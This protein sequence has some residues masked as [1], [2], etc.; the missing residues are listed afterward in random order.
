M[1]DWSSHLPR[2]SSQFDSLEIHVSVSLLRSSITQL[3]IDRLAQQPQLFEGILFGSMIAGHSPSQTL[4]IGNF[5]QTHSTKYDRIADGY[6]DVRRWVVCG[7]D[8]TRFIIRGSAMTRLRSMLSILAGHEEI[9]RSVRG[10][11]K[12][13]KT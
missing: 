2:P 12:G 3:Y 9:V 6:M 7:S 11:K 4:T 1:T 10:V 5:T 8:Q 13:E